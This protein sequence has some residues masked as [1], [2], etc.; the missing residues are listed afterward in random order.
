MQDLKYHQGFSDALG[1]V[2]HILQIMTDNVEKAVKSKKYNIIV[3]I[4]A[5]SVLSVADIWNDV[6]EKNNELI[7]TLAK[8]GKIRYNSNTQESIDKSTKETERRD[9]SGLERSEE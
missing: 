2:T 5:Q 6:N 1:S 7:K 9:S 4:V 3:P 8:K